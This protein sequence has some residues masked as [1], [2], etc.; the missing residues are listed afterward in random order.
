[1]FTIL[2][3]GERENPFYALYHNRRFIEYFTTQEAACEYIST[4][5]ALEAQ[6]EIQQDLKEAA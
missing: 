5:K 4:V 6:P 2:E 3:C 1:M